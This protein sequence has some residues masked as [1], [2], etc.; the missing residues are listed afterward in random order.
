MAKG[1]N[2]VRYTEAELA[3][4]PSESDL[5]RVDRLTETELEA[6]IAADADWRDLPADWVRNA[7]AAFPAGRRESVE[8]ELDPDVLAWFRRQGRDAST[9]INAALRA[10]MIARENAKR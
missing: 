9:T 4:L 8:V 7:A 6:A 5:A 1:R 3:A 10:F 2:I